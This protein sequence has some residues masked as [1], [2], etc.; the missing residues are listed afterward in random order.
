MNKVTRNEYLLNE[1]V[2]RT[3]TAQTLLRYAVKHFVLRDAKDP[4]TYLARR[5][6]LVPMLTAAFDEI[7]EANEVAE[8]L[9][10]EAGRS[11]KTHCS[12]REKDD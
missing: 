11:E 6:I 10:D 3:H 2:C 5:A 8:V 12:A 1:V 4:E 9:L 7:C